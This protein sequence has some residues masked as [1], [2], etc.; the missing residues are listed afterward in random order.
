MSDM[1]ITEVNLDVS[2]LFLYNYR[3]FFC[4]SK[5]FSICWYTVPAFPGTNNLISVETKN[6]SNYS[7]SLAFS[8]CSSGIMCIT[9]YLSFFVV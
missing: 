3:I 1:Q 2:S 4:F 8:N 5:I 6:R 7:G 9:K